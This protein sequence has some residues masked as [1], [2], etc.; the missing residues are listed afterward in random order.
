MSSVSRLSILFSIA[1][2]NSLSAQE[3]GPISSLG[4]RHTPTQQVAPGAEYTG[5]TRDMSWYYRELPPPRKVQIHDLIHI[6]VDERSQ[7]FSDGEL[8]RKTTGQYSAVLTDWLRLDGLD[9]IKPAVQADGDQTVAG[10]LN[11]RLK[12]E[13]EMETNESLR[14]TIAAEVQEILPNGTLKLEASKTIHVN[15]ETWIYHLR[16]IC[17]TDDINPNNTI[18]SEHLAELSITKQEQGAVRDASRRGWLQ[19]MWDHVAWF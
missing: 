19:R 2:V 10:S 1:I 4:Q 17:R 13:A 5:T 14:F 12:A 3:Y 15:E 18:L 6:R 7:A 11:Q 9:S 16:G 8:D